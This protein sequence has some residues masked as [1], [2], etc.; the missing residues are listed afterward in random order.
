MGSDLWISADQEVGLHS[1]TYAASEFQCPPHTHSEY[2]FNFCLD[3][4]MEV[5]VRGCSYL[6]DSGDLLVINP[7]D[8]H[9]PTLGDAAVVSR[10]FGLAVTPKVLRNILGQMNVASRYLEG[11]VFFPDKMHDPNSLRLVRQLVTEL[12]RR[13]DG[14]QIVLASL[15]PQIM[16]YLLR[17]A[18]RPAIRPL[19]SS[20]RQLPCWQMARVFEYMNSHGK[21]AFNE[22][23]LCTQIGCS[24][25]RFIPLFQNS[26]R[27]SPLRC[28]DQILVQKGKNLLLAGA[29]SI[30]EIAYELGFLNESH[31]CRTF[32]IVTGMTANTFRLLPSC[33][34]G[35]RAAS[36]MRFGT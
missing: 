2:I 19:S 34:S 20:R 28:H 8:L 31:F 24:P 9:S 18:L 27:T 14:Y 29:C 23:E 7:G 12:E 17:N 35:A 4:R 15:V 21:S 36:N 22:R 5:V 30:K 6:L 32:R 10:G 16:V 26:V 11:E 25:S 33:T 13:E 1:Y 3:G